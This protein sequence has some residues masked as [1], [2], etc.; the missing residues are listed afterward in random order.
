MC[1]ELLNSELTVAVAYK[2]AYIRIHHTRMHVYNTKGDIT[3]VCITHVYITQTY[4][5]I[6]IYIYIHTYTSH[7]NSELTVKGAFPGCFRSS[8]T[9]SSLLP[10]HTNPHIYIYI[11]IYLLNSELTVGVAY[12]SAYIRIHHTR[13]H[14]YITHI[15]IYIHTY[16]YITP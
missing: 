13:I 8:L 11:Y 1:S 15:Y 2:S 4:I 10:L 12:K 5:Y 7:L 16:I 6:Y 3:L 14:V 9:V